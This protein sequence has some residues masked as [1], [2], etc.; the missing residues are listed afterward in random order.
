MLFSNNRCILPAQA[1]KGGHVAMV[2]LLVAAGADT[3][4]C[5]RVPPPCSLLLL[6]T[7]P[8]LPLPPLPC[9]CR[10]CFLML[11]RWDRPAAAAVV[12]TAAHPAC[13][14]GCSVHLPMMKQ[15]TLTLPMRVLNYNFRGMAV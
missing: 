6:T 13:R 12:V 3:K 15:I 9:L 7:L 2:E 10:R 4:V 11:P 5:A 1:C 14:W 8:L